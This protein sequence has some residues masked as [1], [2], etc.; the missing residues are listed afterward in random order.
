MITIQRR[1]NKHFGFQCKVF[2][3]VYCQRG[4]FDSKRLKSNASHLKL[5]NWTDYLQL[6]LAAKNRILKIDQNLWSLY[7]DSRV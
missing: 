2:Q 3:K 6:I 1:M 5:Y 7:F 4:Q